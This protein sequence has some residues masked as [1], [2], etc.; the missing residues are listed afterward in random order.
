[1]AVYVR[2]EQGVCFGARLLG[3]A[4]L[5]AGRTIQCSKKPTAKKGSANFVTS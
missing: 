2:T 5:T 3:F 4:R 1:M